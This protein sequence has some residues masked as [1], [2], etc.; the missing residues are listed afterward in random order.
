VPIQA[1]AFDLGGVFFPWPSREYFER[2]AVRHGLDSRS[3]DALLWHG[4]DVEAANLG[5]LSAEEYASRCARRLGAD[6]DHVR[7]LLE[8]AFASDQVN[9]ELIRY[10]R[11]LRGRIRVAALTNTWSFGRRLAWER[12]IADLFDV[13]VGSAE[14]GVRKPDPGI[15]HVLLRRLGLDAPEV[16]FVD[17]TPENVETARALGFHAIQHVSTSRTIRELE[18]VLDAGTSPA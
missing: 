9:E 6:A 17:D 14:E 7:G 1:V 12:G 3:L 10:A 18:S 16:A 15:F 4:P 13:F 2:W 8:Y 11:S 5:V